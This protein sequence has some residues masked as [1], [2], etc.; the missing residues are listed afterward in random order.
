MKST[1]RRLSRR[2]SRVPAG[3]PLIRYLRIRTAGLVE[4]QLRL[5]DNRRSNLANQRSLLQVLKVLI[6]IFVT[7]IGT[8]SA[9]LAADKLF[10]GSRV[11]MTVTVTSRSGIDTNSATI[12]AA[13]TAD[14][15][16]GFCKEYV[17]NVTQQCITDELA[18][19]LS[20]EIAA[21]CSSGDFSNFY[22]EIFQFLGPSEKGADAPFKIKNKKSGEIADGSSA[23]GYPVNS[24][25]FKALC[26]KR[27]A[28]RAP[29]KTSNPFTGTW[30]VASEDTNACKAADFDAHENDG[31]IRVGSKNVLYWESSCDIKKQRMVGKSTAENVLQCGGEGETW[32]T[33][34][35]WHS[36]K[37]GT[38]RILTI[39]TVFRSDGADDQ[40]RK[41][42]N[43][44]T[45]ANY[46]ACE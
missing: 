42:P 35:I 45:V 17:G 11:G 29:A 36:Q 24:E 28:T 8:T 23:S 10:Y 20:A 30:S 43:R 16:K 14:D 4:P 5:A 39:V 12:R 18:T 34:E 37:I 27:F 21:N 1:S 41:D 9:A 46:S 15:A 13:H 38:R 7:T 31:L 25:L 33:K 22:G 6:C 2:S 19:P 3:V 40:G 44:P 26:P 32:R